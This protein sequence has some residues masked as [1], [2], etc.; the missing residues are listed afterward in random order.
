MVQNEWKKDYLKELVAFACANKVYCN[1][2]AMIINKDRDKDSIGYIY[3]TIL[4]DTGKVYI[5]QHRSKFYDP[6]YIGSGNRIRNARKKKYTREDFFNQLLEFADSQMLLNQLEIEYIAMAKELFGDKCLNIAE[7]GF[8]TKMIHTTAAKTKSK[9]TYVKR[10][11][12][13]MSHCHTPEAELKSAR[14]HEILYGTVVGH[15]LTPEAKNKKDETFK[16]KYGQRAGRLVEPEI[17]Q[18]S[19]DSRIEKYGT[20]VG[21]M[22]DQDVRAKAQEKTIEN[23]GSICAWLHTEKIKNKALAARA[24]GHNGDYMWMVHNPDSR[25]KAAAALKGMKWSEHS[26]KKRVYNRLVRTGVYYKVEFVDKVHYLLGKTRLKKYMK[27]RDK[28]IDRLIKDGVTR[29]NYKYWKLGLRH[30]S[31]INRPKTI[32]ISKNHNQ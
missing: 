4:R 22:H 24:K 6:S 9:Q 8:D 1:N 3:I 7:G 30:I 13:L 19:L 18:K 32:G 21:R 25:A 29:G 23:H 10:Y 14:T 17:Q 5:G 27:C 26:I 2:K 16:K 28:S 11:G 20:N 12:Q 31:K 15:M